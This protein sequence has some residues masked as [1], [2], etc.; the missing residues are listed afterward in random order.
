[1]AT[2]P[3]PRVLRRLLTA[4]VLVSSGAFVVTIVHIGV[5]RFINQPIGGY[6][7]AIIPVSWLLTT[8]HHTALFAMSKRKYGPPPIPN[9]PITILPNNSRS[10]VYRPA[11]SH[12]SSGLL[13]SSSNIHRIRPDAYPSYAKSLVNCVV[14][15]ILAL[16]WSGG[17]WSTIAT[18]VGLAKGEYRLKQQ[19]GA[20]VALSV[21]EGIFGYTEVVLAW[22]LFSRFINSRYPRL[23]RTQ[24]EFIKMEG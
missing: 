11:S 12:A 6:S 14:S 10:S 15:F 22:V 19:P 23:N 5:F 21:V 8:G 18:A 17:A 2:R 9:S 24:R 3:L 20:E 16:L 4:S 7:L 13:D 1:M